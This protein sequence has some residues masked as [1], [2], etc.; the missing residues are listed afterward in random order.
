[1]K[2]HRILGVV[3]AIQFCVVLSAFGQGGYKAEAIGAAPANVPAPTLR[4]PIHFDGLSKLTGQS[5]E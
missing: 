2:L 4:V 5:F 1:M 3:L